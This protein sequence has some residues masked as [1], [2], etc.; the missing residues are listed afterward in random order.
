V[1]PTRCGLR[2]SLRP[3]LRP[4]L[5][6]RTAGLKGIRAGLAAAASPRMVCG[7]LRASFA[8]RRDTPAAAGRPFSQMVISSPVG[9]LSCR[10]PQYGWAVAARQH[11]ACRERC[12]V[13][14]ALR[15]FGASTTEPLTCCLALQGSRRGPGD[16][17][18]FTPLILAVLGLV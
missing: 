4:R 16:S 15:H 8:V 3:V 5:R 12:R 13:R 14:V 9:E 11:G 6:G 18:P 1:L 2:S 7:R 17:P 10:V